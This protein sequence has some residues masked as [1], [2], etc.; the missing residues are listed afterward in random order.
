VAFAI[1]CAA[2]FS[3]E[4]GSVVNAVAQGH[5][6]VPFLPDKFEPI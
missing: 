2:S 6:F 4:L 5:H 3:M 1:A